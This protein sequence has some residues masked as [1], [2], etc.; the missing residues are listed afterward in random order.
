MFRSQERRNHYL[1]EACRGDAVLA[2][3]TLNHFAALAGLLHKSTNWSAIC[4][5]LPRN[6]L[7]DSLSM[8]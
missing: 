3:L 4:R 1:Y 7:I 5:L 6:R 2:T 8:A